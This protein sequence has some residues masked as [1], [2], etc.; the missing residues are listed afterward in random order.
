MTTGMYQSSSILFLVFFSA[1]YVAFYIWRSKSRQYIDNFYIAFLIFAAIG[2]LDI[3]VYSIL[4]KEGYRE[5]ALFLSQYGQIILFLHAIVIS[6]YV[7][8]RVS[9]NKQISLA[10]TLLYS[11][12]SI[13]A[14]YYILQPGAMVFLPSSSFLVL[15]SNHPITWGIFQALFG[16]IILGLFW[17]VFHNI[18]LWMNKS[19]KYEQKYLI[20]SIA[21][22][23]YA[24]IGYYEAHGYVLFIVTILLRLTLLLSVFIA[25]LAFKYQE[26][27]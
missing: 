20:A 3:G 26:I 19:D 15:H 5:I 2:W 24:I 27:K 13:Y 10:I 17:D 8:F 18:Y 12:L 21:I 4:Y 9:R 1:L 22:I 23:I 7:A 16:I 11:A 14:L 6:Y 25:Y